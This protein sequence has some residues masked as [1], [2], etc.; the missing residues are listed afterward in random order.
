MPGAPAASDR[1]TGVGQAPGSDDTALAGGPESG[2]ESPRRARRT[3][4]AA[5]ASL[6]VALLPCLP[7]LGGLL[8]VALGLLARSEIERS[9]GRLG[10]SK[11]ATSG[12][13]LGTVH[14]LAAVTLLGSA[15][16]YVARP[17]SD[18]AG[19]QRPTAA[20]APHPASPTPLPRATTRTYTGKPNSAADGVSTAHVGAITLVDVGPGIA[21]LRSELE[22]QVKQARASDEQVVVWLV[23]P[24]C[25]PCSGVAASLSDSRMQRALRKVRL[26]RLNVREFYAELRHLG[27]PIEYVPGFAL[28]GDDNLPR[29]YLHGGE[30]D[31]DVAANIAPVLAK[32]I[33][34]NYLNRRHPWRGG[35]R[36]DETPI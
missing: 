31:E 20:T 17:A 9:A 27:V 5:V 21:S 33:R 36:D 29:D 7:V 14:L 25:K 3:S 1:L 32:F 23:A 19:G 26:V 2:N 13:V 34:G 10:G 22:R 11:L 15:I 6:L 35:T 12:I 8:A 24:D 28:L 16:A 18:P 30:W 4:T